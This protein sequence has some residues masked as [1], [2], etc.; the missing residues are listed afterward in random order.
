MWSIQIEI[1][2]GGGVCSLCLNYCRESTTVRLLR[3]CFQRWVWDARRVAL[4][5]LT[6]CLLCVLLSSARQKPRTNYLELDRKNGSRLIIFVIGGITYSEMRCA[7]EVSQAHKSCEVIIGSTHI[8]TPRKLL[9]DIKMLNKSKD[10]VSFK[11]E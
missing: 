2:K 1:W 11:D 3:Y 9:D 4:G 5:V 7:Y 10:K 8:L 6:A